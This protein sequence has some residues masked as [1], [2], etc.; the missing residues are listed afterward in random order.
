[1]HS[2]VYSIPPPVSFW[3]SSTALTFAGIDDVGCAEFPG[4]IQPF[5]HDIKRDDFGA[6]AYHGRHNGAQSH[7]SDSENRDGGTRMT[8]SGC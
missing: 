3:I 5:F 4:Q 7:G 1:M 8:A 2:R 6:A